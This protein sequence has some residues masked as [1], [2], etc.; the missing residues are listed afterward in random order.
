MKKLNI[1][2]ALSLVA[3]HVPKA[4]FKVDEAAKTI[5]GEVD[6][7]VDEAAVEANTPVKTSPFVAPI[8]EGATDEDSI[9]QY[10]QANIQTVV[11]GTVVTLPAAPAQE[12]TAQA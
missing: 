6:S 10:L 11:G 1:L 2:L 3:I 9:D 8:V 4:Q 5:T 7:F 12:A